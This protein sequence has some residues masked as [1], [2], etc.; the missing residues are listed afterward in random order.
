MNDAIEVFRVA[1]NM[2]ELFGADASLR[3]VM[4]ADAALDEGDSGFQFLEGR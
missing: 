4:R 2:L 1:D 3:A